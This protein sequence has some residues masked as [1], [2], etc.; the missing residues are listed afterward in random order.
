M[1]AKRIEEL[2]IYLVGKYKGFDHPFLAEVISDLYNEDTASS[3]IN[4]LAQ[5]YGT[6]RKTICKQFEQHI[7]KTPSELKK[8][9]RFRQALEFRQRLRSIKTK[10]SDIAYQFNFFDQSHLIKDFR[11]ITGMTPKDFLSL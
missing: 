9:I 1:C 6:T 5:K 8:I 2:E 11:S 4:K 10:F 3:G 7:G